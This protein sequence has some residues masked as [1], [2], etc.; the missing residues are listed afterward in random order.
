MSAHERQDAFS[1]IFS[2]IGPA[3]DAAI[4][5]VGD[6]KSAPAVRNRLHTISLVEFL[7]RHDQFPAFLIWLIQKSRSPLR[8]SLTGPAEKR[9]AVSRTLASI[10]AISCTSGLC[11]LRYSRPSRMPARYSAVTVFAMI[12]SL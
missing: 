11:E 2:R 12:N 7:A 1:A 9:F 4:H 6:I 10:S 3:G 5:T 8:I